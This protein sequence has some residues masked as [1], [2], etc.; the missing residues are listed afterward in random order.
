MGTIRSGGHLA[1]LVYADDLPRGGSPRGGLAELDAVL[2]EAG[3][4]L[5]R[6][7][8]ERVTGGGSPAG[9]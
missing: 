3:L 5:E 9:S 2:L 8:R 6:A 4:A 7:L 1:A